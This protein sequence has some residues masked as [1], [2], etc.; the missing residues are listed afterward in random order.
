MK[1]RAPFNIS[2]GFGIVWIDIVITRLITFLGW[3]FQPEVID[4]LSTLNLQY[5]LRRPTPWSDNVGISSSL[6]MFIIRE[7]HVLAS[8]GQHDLH[9]KAYNKGNTYMSSMRFVWFLICRYS[10]IY[11]SM[12]LLP[13][14]FTKV[15]VSR[16]K[17]S[18]N[19][20]IFS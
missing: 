7:P 18:S 14:V 2:S 5:V 1:T 20:Q 8:V 11:V 12:Y 6:M 10:R 13:C 4:E 15:C 3:S 9:I 16:D 17:Q 19:I